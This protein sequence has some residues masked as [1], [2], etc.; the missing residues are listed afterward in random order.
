MKNI[1]GAWFGKGKTRGEEKLL[2]KL[3]EGGEKYEKEVAE[4]VWKKV[5]DRIMVKLKRWWRD[6]SLAEK[7]AS[8]IG[9]S[10][11]S[12]EN[13]GTR[14][15]E[16]NDLNSIDFDLLVQ[17][18]QVIVDGTYALHTTLRSLLDIRVAVSF[19]DK[20]R[21]KKVQ[22]NVSEMEVWNHCSLL[23]NGVRGSDTRDWKHIEPDPHHC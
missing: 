21:W 9:C 7:V 14:A 12:V 10:V 6:K 5:A 20:W 22:F 11:I 15:D 1:N 3:N 2:L 4:L 23:L 13:Y 19:D 18:L 16:R 17:S 8:V